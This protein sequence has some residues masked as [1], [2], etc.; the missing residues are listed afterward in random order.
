VNLL[1]V[2]PHHNCCT[3]FSENV[4]MMM[5]LLLQFVCM[6]LY[7]QQLALQQVLPAPAEDT[8]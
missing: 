8:I 5:M 2:L 1:S 3:P 7:W 6:G 4:M